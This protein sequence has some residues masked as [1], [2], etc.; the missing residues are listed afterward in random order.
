MCVVAIS[1]FA[2]DGAPIRCGLC[3]AFLGT[4][5]Y[6]AARE[7]LP[8]HWWIRAFAAHD[9]DHQRRARRPPRRMF[10]WAWFDP[11]APIRLDCHGPGC[12]RVI[13]VKAQTLARK[14]VGPQPIFV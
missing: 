2:P 3:R 8:D 6:S 14:A 10:Q 11:R 1:E 12:H 13:N 7:G 4:L 5:H 9:S